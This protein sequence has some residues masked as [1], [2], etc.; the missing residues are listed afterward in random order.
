[1]KSTSSPYRLEMPEAEVWYAPGFFSA[2]ESNIFFK[3]LLEEIQWR[4]DRVRVFGKWY[5]QPRLTALYASNDH[6]YT[7]SGLTLHP[8]RYTPLLQEIRQRVEN[9]THCS[10]SSCLLNLYRNGSDSNGWHAD[11]EKEL[12]RNPLIASVSFGQDRSF[13]FRH[14]KDK[15]LKKKIVLENGSMLL[16]KGETQHSWQH[17]LPKSKKVLKPRINLTFRNILPTGQTELQK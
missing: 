3:R 13:H 8:Q 6:A 7:Y 11:D 4:S 1:M 9:H 14:K 5:D 2:A 16:M 15:S 12:G 10:F 17:Q